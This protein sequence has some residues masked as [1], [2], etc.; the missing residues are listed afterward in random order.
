MHSLHVRIQE[1]LSG[2]GGPGPTARKQPGRRLFFFIS[3]Q[4]ILKFTEGVQWFY[5]IENY[6]GGATFSRGRGGV[7]GPN[8]NIYKNPYNLRVSR[9]SGTPIYPLWIRTWSHHQITLPHYMCKLPDIL[10]PWICHNGI[11]CSIFFCYFKGYWIFRKHMGIFAS[12]YKG[13]LPVYFKEYCYLPLPLPSKQASSLYNTWVF[14]ERN[15]SYSHSVV[16]N[17]LFNAPS[18]CLFSVFGSCFV[19]YTSVPSL[20]LQSS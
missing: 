8:D 9:G 20:V 11:L 3:P 18:I 16:V 14:S 6:P 2:E 10:I 4:L 13:Y 17:L 7:C 1:F 15:S 12:S 5:Y 19:M